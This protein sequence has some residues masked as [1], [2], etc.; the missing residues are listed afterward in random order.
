MSGYLYHLTYAGRLPS[1]I[2]N[3][4]CPGAAPAIG[5]DG[6]YR[7]HSSGR[8][9][10]TVGGGAYFWRGRLEAFAEHSSDNVFE[11]ELVP[12]VLRVEMDDVLDDPAA[13]L[14][15]DDIGTRDA[16]ANAYFMTECLSL[17]EH[18][19]EIYDGTNWVYLDELGSLDLSLA[20]DFEE[21][22]GETLASFK[23]ESPFF[24]PE[25]HP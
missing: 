5:T 10:F 23:F 14:H 24:P 20:F 4:L 21:Y 7:A 18:L 9:F 13:V 12:V 22:D 8:L 16:L 15:A 3:G 25:L 11:D 2:E 1:I 6:A 19:F 17:D